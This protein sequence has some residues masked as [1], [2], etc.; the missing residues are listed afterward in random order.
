LGCTLQR[1]FKCHRTK[2]PTW[3][4]PG[5]KYLCNA[6]GIRCTREKKKA[7]KDGPPRARYARIHRPQPAIAAQAGETLASGGTL[8]MSEG[9][10]GTSGAQTAN[11]RGVLPLSAQT[12]AALAGCQPPTELPP[13]APYQPP[14]G[15]PPASAHQPPTGLPR[16]SAYQPPTGLPPTSVYQPPTGLPPA[17][18]YQPPTGTRSA[19]ASPQTTGV[20]TG[21]GIEPPTSMSSAAPSEPPTP[22]PPTAEPPTSVTQDSCPCVNTH[23]LG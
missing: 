1:C 6:C 8:V 15:L 4:R 11:S 7:A 20:P 2:T 19:A 10:L 12:D 16:V 5:G 23:V 18:A 13:A 9:T 22:V 21:P 17:S 14:T 3:R